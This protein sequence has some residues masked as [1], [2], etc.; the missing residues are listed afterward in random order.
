M[1]S[2]TSRCGRGDQKQKRTQCWASVCVEEGIT[3]DDDGKK[4][5]I[6]KNEN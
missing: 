3:T 5:R 4:C 2:P 6:Y 1:S